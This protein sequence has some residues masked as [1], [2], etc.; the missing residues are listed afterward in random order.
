MIFVVCVRL[1]LAC[2][3]EAVNCFD[4]LTAESLGFAG[5][6]Y[7]HVLVGRHLYIKLTV[8]SL[9]CLYRV[10]TST[11]SLRKSPTHAL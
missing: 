6:V 1:T 10:K 4:G 11:H 7:E 3:G 8:Q 2:G 9:R 5:L